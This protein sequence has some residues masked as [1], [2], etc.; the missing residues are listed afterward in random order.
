MHAVASLLDDGFKIPVL[1]YRIGL[2]PILGVLPIAGDSI[3]AVVGLYIV[4]ESA[5]L[6]VSYGTIARQ[7]LNIAV[8]LGIGSVPVLGDVFDLAF[9]SNRRNVNLALEDLGA[10]ME[11]ED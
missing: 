9:R 4:G 1:D 10:E 11:L 2:D 6:G 7:L 8:D 5:R 3:T